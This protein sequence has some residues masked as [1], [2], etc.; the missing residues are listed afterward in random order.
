MTSGRS[1]EGTIRQNEV[2]MYLDF[3]D[4]LASLRGAA[5][6]KDAGAATAATAAFAKTSA[7]YLAKH[8]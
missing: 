3:E 1:I 8:R 4:S 7:S 6:D 5:E 2:D